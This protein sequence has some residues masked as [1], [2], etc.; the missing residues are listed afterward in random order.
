MNQWER[1]RLHPYLTE[2]VL[3]RCPVLTPFA[4]VA[5]FHHERTDGSGYHRGRRENNSA[6]ALACSQPADV[7]H[8]MCQHRP[9]RPAHTPADAASLLLDEVDAGRLG[10]AE[11]EAVLPAAGQTARPPN[12]ARPASLTERE[13]DVLRLIARG[14]SNKQVAAALG[15]LAQD[16][17]A[18]H[19]APPRQGRGHHPGRGDPV[20]HGTRPDVALTGRGDGVNTPCATTAF[21]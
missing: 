10:R 14:H 19:R 5:A 21:G 7:H 9:H 4:S 2:R 3:H 15:D 1:V 20:R 13:V 8:A 6:V 11:V 12:V 17:G 16:G 18:P